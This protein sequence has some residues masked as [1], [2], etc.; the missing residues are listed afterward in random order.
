MLEGIAI[1]K[2]NLQELHFTKCACSYPCSVKRFVFLQI[3]QDL[4]KLDMTLNLINFKL[5][6]HM[7]F[8]T[9]Q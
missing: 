5:K 6:L 1:E 8:G 4:K 9:Y 3:I 7:Q 2:I